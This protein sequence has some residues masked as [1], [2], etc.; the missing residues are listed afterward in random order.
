M[1][2]W[3]NANMPFPRKRD[4]EDAE[5][6]IGMADGPKGAPQERRVIQHSCQRM[7]A[8]A[9]MTPQEMFRGS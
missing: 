9:G 6:N 2:H 3:N 5:T 8:F 7:P 1:T 4:R